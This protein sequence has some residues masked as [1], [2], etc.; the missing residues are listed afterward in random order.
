MKNVFRDKG[1]QV[2]LTVYIAVNI[3]LFVIDLMTSPGKT[4][5]FWP[6]IGWGIG[7]IGHALSILSKAKNRPA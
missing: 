3:L 4:W 5:F 1:F 6:L 7:I 2:H